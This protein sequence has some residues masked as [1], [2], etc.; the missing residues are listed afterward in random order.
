MIIEITIE[1]N[2]ILDDNDICILEKI[3]IS[4]QE[5]S[6]LFICTPNNFELLH[7]QTKEIRLVGPSLLNIVKQSRQLLQVIEKVG[8]IA[9]VIFGKEKINSRTEIDKKVIFKYSQHYI[10]GSKELLP[11]I[12]LAENRTDACFYR[13]LA[14][15]YSEFNFGRNF[16]F[17]NTEQ[18][19]G[20]GDTTSDEFE[21][22][23]NSYLFRPFYCIVDSD[24]A[25]PRQGH[26]GKTAK[27]VMTKAEASP[28]LKF[29]FSILDMMEL[30]N[31]LPVKMIEEVNG[32]ENKQQS[33]LYLK[34][35]S[36]LYFMEKEKPELFFHSDLKEGVNFKKA[37][38]LDR[39]HGGFWLKEKWP[40]INDQCLVDRICSCNPCCHIIRKGPSKLLEKSLGL[41]QTKSANDIKETMPDYLW[42]V[43]CKYGAIVFSWG[44][45]RPNVRHVV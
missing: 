20:G 9:K 25:H 43:W 8:F 35:I 2:Y 23:Y 42:S 14:R 40:T 31:I 3:A 21:H 17:I 13:E 44:C 6:H 27:G 18:V 10:S 32:N 45:A 4:H 7:A 19:G 29:N 26:I 33:N 22:L 41:V 11:A 37:L 30:E 34:S 12:I 36:N 15:V 5:A 24:K 16:L 28:L 38:E 39:S 1:P